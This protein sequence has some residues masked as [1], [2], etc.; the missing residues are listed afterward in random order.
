MKSK[1][2]VVYCV[3]IYVNDI[4]K[5]LM[6]LVDP[7][8][9]YISYKNTTSAERLASMHANEYKNVKAR[10][11]TLNNIKVNDSVN[12]KDKPCELKDLL[13]LQ[14][15]NKTQLFLVVKQGARRFAKDVHVVIILE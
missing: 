14:T 6:E 4:D 13:L 3:E 1:V 12:C 8:I 7:I 10:Y 2:L 9:K 5:S 11:E 15:A